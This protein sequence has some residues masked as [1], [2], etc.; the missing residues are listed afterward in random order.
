MQVDLDKP[1]ITS[2]RVGKLVQR[3]TYEG[4]SALCF[5]CGR[6]GHKRDSCLYYIKLAIR[7]KVVLNENISTKQKE[8]N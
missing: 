4:V 7:E 6:F 2:V 5:S 3:V 1:L 8:T